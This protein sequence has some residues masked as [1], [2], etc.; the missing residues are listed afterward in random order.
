MQP[1]V[2]GRIIGRKIFDSR[3]NPTVEVE[4]TVQDESGAVV[5]SGRAA[6]PSG[7]SRGKHEVVAF[8][9]GGV[10][11]SLEKIREL[12]SKLAG[13]GA[14]AQEEVDAACREFDGTSDLHEVGG[15][16][17]VAVSMAVAKAVAS[18]AGVPLYK[19]LGGKQGAWLPYPLGN[20][21]GGGK[22][23]GRAAPDIQ[24]FLVLPVGA[25]SF[26]LAASANAEV[27]KR[28]RKLIEMKD[29]SFTGGKGD[30]GAWAPNLGDR[31][32]LEIISRSCEEISDEVGFKV[33]PALDVAASSLYDEGGK[34]YVYEREGE[35]RD[36]GEQ[37][38]FILDLIDAYGLVY[39]EDPIQE[40][41]FESFA[42]ITRKVGKNCIT[43][44]DDLFVTN[45]K[46]IKR[47]VEAEAANAVLIKPNQVGTL[48]DTQK[49]VKLS[50]ENNYVPVMSH[51][52]GE[53]PDD[54]IAHL[55]VGFGCP[56]IKTGVVGGERV[57]KL[58]ELIRIEEELGDRARMGELPCR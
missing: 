42:E 50:K 18:A 40:D 47:G 37:V 6:A 32:A 41:D 48:T 34:K 19:H 9:E 3:G 23:A 30:E 36:A 44:G 4:A 39:A 31:D 2:I 25:K 51:R 46:R 24:E 55:A 11:V 49:A 53:T 28:V 10:D 58:N 29:K 38:E 7:A 17:V 14:G 12:A 16:A 33:R 8:P 43:C 52:S 27:H 45:V 26:E 22:H 57:A 35:Q 20:V 1:L 5:G 15:N 13:L 21:L 56:I 54:T